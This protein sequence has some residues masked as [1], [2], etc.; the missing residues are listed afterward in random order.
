MSCCKD[1]PPLRFK[2]SCRRRKHISLTLINHQSCSNFRRFLFLLPSLH[3]SLGLLAPEPIQT[4][5]TSIN[6]PAF[7]ST[8][9]CQLLG[10]NCAV[11]SEFALTWPEFCERGGATDIH[12]DGWGL[13]Y[14]AGNNSQ[15]LRQFHD[16]EAAATSP[17]AQFL[18][19]QSIRTR[20]LLAHIR[21]ATLG[22]VDLVNVHPFARE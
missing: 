1:A 19:C 20:N 17:L 15:G 10:M 21:Y 13:A 12:A 6:K 18:G 5:R 7:T 14:Y 9:L 11:E 4:Q 22:P 2:A 16:V 8:L 3:S